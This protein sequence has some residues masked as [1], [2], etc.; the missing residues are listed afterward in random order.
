MVKLKANKIKEP[1]KHKP[2]HLRDLAVQEKQFPVNKNYK[3]RYFPKPILAKTVP[4]LQSTR[5]LV[6]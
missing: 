2:Q 3:K 6:P 1:A 5:C 4:K